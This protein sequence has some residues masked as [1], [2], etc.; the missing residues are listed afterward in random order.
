MF[1]AILPEAPSVGLKDEAATGEERL[2][3]A[4][5]KMP[6]DTGAVLCFTPEGLGML[7]HEFRANGIPMYRITARC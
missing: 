5:E 7:Q 2:L 6:T 3:L 4:A 1:F